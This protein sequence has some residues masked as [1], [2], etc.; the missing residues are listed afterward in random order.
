MEL[1]KAIEVMLDAQ[2]KLRSKEGINSPPFMSE[3]M[4][5]LAQATGAIEDHLAIL[6]K[7]YD[8][9]QAELLHR[10]LVTEGTS[11][12]NA[13]KRVK[14]ELGELKGQ[15]SYLSRI[16]SSAWKQISTI[17]SRWNHIQK[18]NVGQI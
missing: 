1:Q 13:E 12:T 9:K 18:E 4:M 16:V 14:I 17:Q 10:F 7:Q 15:L 8:L 2:K 11:A 6:E 3:Q 5:R